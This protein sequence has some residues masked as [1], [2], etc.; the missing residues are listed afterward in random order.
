MGGVTP[1]SE[2]FLS[3]NLGPF[4][5]RCIFSQTRGAYGLRHSGKDRNYARNFPGS[6]G[7]A[8]SKRDAK[9]DSKTNFASALEKARSWQPRFI[10]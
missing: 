9:T 2:R 1:L 8:S 4:Q 10:D 3:E 7:N 5:H 6:R